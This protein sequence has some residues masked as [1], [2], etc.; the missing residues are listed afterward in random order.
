MRAT[1]TVR[2]VGEVWEVN[3]TGVPTPLGSYPS[4]NAAVK[5]ARDAAERDMPSRLVVRNRKGAIESDRPYGRDQL[6][7]DLAGLR[8]LEE[9]LPEGLPPMP[10]MDEG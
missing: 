9:P 6:A 1:Y 8:A 5:A 10:E 2:P 7:D 4:R 3:C